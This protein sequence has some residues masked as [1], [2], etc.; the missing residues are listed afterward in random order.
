M[1]SGTVVGTEARDAAPT[2]PPTAVKASELAA[3]V[4]GVEGDDCA[5]G[6][7]GVFIVPAAR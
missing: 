7:T 5:E 4:A 1:A 6:G 2:S 3:G